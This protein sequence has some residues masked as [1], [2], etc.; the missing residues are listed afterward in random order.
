MRALKV[1]FHG[2]CSKMTFLFAVTRCTALKKHYFPLDYKSCVIIDVRYKLEIIIIF[3]FGLRWSLLH[4]GY[5]IIYQKI[6]YITLENAAFLYLTEKVYIPYI[7][8]NS[9]FTTSMNIPPRSGG[10]LKPAVP[11]FDLSSTLFIRLYC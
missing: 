3:L 2:C 9:F 7:A 6:L 4:H 10:H 11:L 5:T 8:P 1:S